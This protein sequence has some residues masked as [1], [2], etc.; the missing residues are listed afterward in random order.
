[1][2][3][4]DTVAAQAYSQDL[5]GFTETYHA[6]GAAGTLPTLQQKWLAAANEA[7]TGLRLDATQFKAVLRLPAE[8]ALESQ[9]IAAQPDA[10]EIF[11]RMS[12]FSSA[13]E[14][15]TRA[16]KN[17]PKRAQDWMRIQHQ[18]G[19]F[20]ARRPLEVLMSGAPHALKTLQSY[21]YHA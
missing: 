9:K 3:A 1:M 6:A 18:G 2:S 13:A 8:T 15:L 4:A 17:D 12:L 20:A 5:A 11:Y 14:H 7:A 16:L 19:P 21:L 10:P